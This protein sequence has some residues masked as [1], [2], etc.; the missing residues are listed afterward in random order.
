[1]TTTSTGRPRSPDRMRR[2]NH[3]AGDMTAT[4]P[5]TKGAHPAGQAAGLIVVGVDGSAHSQSVMHWAVTEAARRQAA[6]IVCH[7]AP[8]SAAGTTT[9]DSV[10]ADA[11]EQV[12]GQP[13]LAV[14]YRPLGGRPAEQ[15][16]QA[17][18]SAD[19]LVVGAPG[20]T[21][22]GALLHGS[23]SEQVAREA[24]CP[25]VVVR[26][27][28]PDTARQP[29]VV[30][31][32]DGSTDAESAIEFAFDE[33]ARRGIALHAIHAFDPGAVLAMPY[34]P[35]D[36]LNGLRESTATAFAAQ[37][38][39][40][41]DAHPDVDVSFEMVHGSA[42]SI[43]LEESA[44]ADLLVLGSHRH[45]NVATRLL[46]STSSAALHHALCPVA[47]VHRQPG[48]PTPARE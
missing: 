43:L 17:A 2:L 9:T 5:D 1:M 6:L 26:D 40:H 8:K 48:G 12:R 14:Y 13:T 28:S 33:A 21:A 35:E 37:L 3:P 32:V 47:I 4:R 31:G 42:A 10:L 25:V 44:G 19:L 22:V 30:V 39:Q 45:S 46:G 15:L 20:R 41:A 16:V 36:M 18:A 11:V 29:R 27:I 23:V 38:T 7:V 24:A 34:L